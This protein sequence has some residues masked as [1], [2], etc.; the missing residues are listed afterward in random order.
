VAA[1]SDE[2]SPDYNELLRLSDV[3]VKGQVVKIEEQVII[4]GGLNGV[5]HVGIERILRGEPVKTETTLMDNRPVVVRER[6]ATTVRVGWW[7]YSVE[8]ECPCTLSKTNL[9]FLKRSHRSEEVYS[10]VGKLDVS[11][12]QTVLEEIQKRK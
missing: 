12:E 7:R 8:K 6:A 3:I 11:A 10:V 9:W 1:E 5:G 4:G 2:K